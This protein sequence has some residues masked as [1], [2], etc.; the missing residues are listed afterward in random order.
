MGLALT[1][2]DEPRTNGT[3]EVSDLLVCAAQ[4]DERAWREILDRY[5]PRVF[6]LARSR[7]QSGE[8]AEEITQSVFVTISTKLAGGEYSEKGRFEP[9]LFRV[10][11]NRI[12]DEARRAKRHAR[13]TDPE[14]FGGVTA[15]SE[16]VRGANDD[17]LASL[18]QGI[19]QLP[20][21]DQ[22]IIHLRH[23][24]QMSFRQIAELL[25]EPLGT[26]LARH[27]RA[28]RKLRQLLTISTEDPSP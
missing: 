23:Q 9:W 20:A 7:F 3:E 8:L 28:L 6:A 12:R 4:G 16:A 27:H 10:A 18:R 22:E 25:D 1:A 11:M 26:L 15:P 2:R 19:S 14:A 21:A 13:P 24:G 5:A 17:D